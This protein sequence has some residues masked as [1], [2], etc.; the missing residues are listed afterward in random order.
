MK[1]KNQIEEPS[2]EKL[3]RYITGE[4]DI[5]EAAEIEAW[6]VASTQ[7]KEKLNRA[8][9]LV[10]HADEY[11][12]L[13]N[14]NQDVAWNKIRSKI[15]DT[16]SVNNKTNKFRRL[17]VWIYKYAAAIAILVL[18]GAAGYFYYSSN[19]FQQGITQFSTDNFEVVDNYALPD[20]STVSLNG[21]STL[22]HPA[23]FKEDIREITLTGEAYL[24]VKPDENRPFII[25]TNGARIRVL[26]TSFSV[27]AYPD[28][29]TLEVVVATGA[30]QVACFM[31]RNPEAEKEIILKTG[32]KGLLIH[33]T[34][35]VEKSNNTDPNY[36]SWK[37]HDFTFDQM[38]LPEVI[39]LL[40]EVYHTDIKMD[41]DELENL[42]L[43]ARFDNKSEKFILEVISLTF[44]LELVFRNNSYVLSKKSVSNN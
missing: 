36:L 19:L 28:K 32:E 26:G 15:Y 41:D 39:K 43:T 5:K 16:S 7:N 12:R 34:K 9:Q 14:F 1:T 40:K 21:N 22:K 38:P 18:I 24:E 42:L 33:S 35:Y 23:K 2:W 8:R 10:L 17:S 3:V 25:N 11:Y 6:A 4:A 20:G 31:D 44:D 29:D 13:K 27:N 37:T 30:V